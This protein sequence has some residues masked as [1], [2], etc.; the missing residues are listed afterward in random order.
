[1]AGQDLNLSHDEWQEYPAIDLYESRQSIDWEVI[2]QTESASGPGK[3]TGIA[4]NYIYLAFF[5]A[6]ISVG[7]LKTT[8]IG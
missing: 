2:A 5:H 3:P 6:E 1:L 4:E 7:G 8:I